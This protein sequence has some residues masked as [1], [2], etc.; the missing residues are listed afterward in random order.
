LGEL[1]PLGISAVSV[2]GAERRPEYAAMAVGVFRRALDSGKPPSEHDLELLR[3]AFSPEGTTAA[4]FVGKPGEE[5]LAGKSAPEKPKGKIKNVLSTVRSD[6][7]GGD[8]QRVPVLMYGELRRGAAVRIAVSD[9]RGNTAAASGPVPEP[10][11]PGK[12][13]LTPAILKTQLFNTLGTPYYCAGA[14]ASVEPGLYLPSADVSHVR[15]EALSRLSA[16]RSAAPAVSVGKLPEIL[17]YEGGGEKPDLTF[18]VLK[19]SQ[20]SAQLA[21]TKP[22]VLYVPLS[23]LKASPASITPFW[24]NGVTSICAVL[25]PV[26]SDANAIDVYREL[27]SLRDMHIDEVM[28]NSISQIAPARILGFKLRG[29]LNLNVGNSYTLK[30]LKE[31][32]LISALLSPELRLDHIRELSKYIDTELPAYGRLP[33]MVTENCIIRCLAGVCACEAAQHL[34]DRQGRLYPVMRAEGCRS[35]VYSPDKLFIAGRLKDFEELGLW[36]LHLAFTT[37]NAK[38]CASIAGRYLLLNKYEPNSKSKGLYYA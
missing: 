22:K 10:S 5:M 13:E 11:G 8:S 21:G 35:V 12:R 23:E 29:G 26:V 14:K 15:W 32:G 19:A 27:H 34:R 17:K 33:L 2:A 31:Q 37:E 24:E 18:S 4:F 30:A 6:Y 7:L 1:A 25:P 3:E 28:V 36:C 38:E 20:L 16:L 9:D